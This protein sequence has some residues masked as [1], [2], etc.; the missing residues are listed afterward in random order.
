MGESGGFLPC[1]RLSCLTI[2]CHI[3]PHSWRGTGS[4]CPAGAAPE[5]PEA[6]APR[7]PRRLRAGGKRYG[8]RLQRTRARLGS[9]A[10]AGAPRR[11]R[12]KHNSI[13]TSKTFGFI[14]G[15]GRCFFKKPEKD[16][17]ALKQKQTKILNY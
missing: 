12:V 6:L 14:L 5:P 1:L 4:S 15:G 7:I 16:H 9:E 10:E 17:K 13:K 3:G 11:G 8:S 2:R